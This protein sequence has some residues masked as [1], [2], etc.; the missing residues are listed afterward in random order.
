VE[1]L[2]G[3]SFGDEIIVEGGR[4]LDLDKDNL[5]VEVFA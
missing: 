5:P 2:S 1:I 4:I 3:V